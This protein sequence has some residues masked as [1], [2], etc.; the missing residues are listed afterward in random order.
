MQCR[1]EAGM[2]AWKGRST[3]GQKVSWRK[4]DY[5]GPLACLPQE[6]FPFVKRTRLKEQSTTVLW[7]L[8]L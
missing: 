1:L 7:Y 4:C 3:I 6:A 2:A 8:T 5:S